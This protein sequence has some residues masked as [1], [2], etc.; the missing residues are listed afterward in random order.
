MNADNRNKMEFV[1]KV[2]GMV[3]VC[4]GIVTAMY[5]A[6]LIIFLGN[7]YSQL[8]Q[9]SKYNSF[10]AKELDN[11]FY[12]LFQ[13]ERQ[14][15]FKILILSLI[16]IPFGMYLMKSDNFFVRYCYP[17]KADDGFSEMDEPQFDR[18]SDEKDIDNIEHSYEAGIGYGTCPE[19]NADLIKRQVEHGKYAGRYILSCSNYPLCKQIFPYKGQQSE[20]EQPF[21]L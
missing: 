6:Y 11:A 4:S 14:L 15:Y 8:Q 18:L 1:S 2:I 10:M 21:R 3:I 7:D 16:P 9:L 12:V 13:I 19:C 5:L 17:E 20:T